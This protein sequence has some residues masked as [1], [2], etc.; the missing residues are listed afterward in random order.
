MQQQAKQDLWNKTNGCIMLL[1]VHT[2]V[3][4]AHFICQ[5]QSLTLGVAATN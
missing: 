5:F 4:L 1:H 3:A 2:T